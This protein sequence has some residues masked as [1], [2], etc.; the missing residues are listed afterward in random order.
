MYV[1]TEDA[2]NASYLVIVENSGGNRAFGVEAE[3]SDIMYYVQ[4]EAWNNGA[5]TIDCTPPAI[6]SPATLPAAGGLDFDAT[7]A[8]VGVAGGGSPTPNWHIMR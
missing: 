5:A 8:D 4:N 1:S 6:N 2:A 3:I 7:G